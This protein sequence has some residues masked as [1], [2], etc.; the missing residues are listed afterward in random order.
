[1]QTKKKKKEMT[2]NWVR[3]RSAGVEKG[4]LLPISGF[5]S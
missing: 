1:M 4:S 2:A 5:V 3:A